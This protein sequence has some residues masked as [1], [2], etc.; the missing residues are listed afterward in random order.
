MAWFEL[1]SKGVVAAKFV[2]HWIGNLRRFFREGRRPSQPRARRPLGESKR[3]FDFRVRFEFGTVR[4]GSGAS[5]SKR[6][7]GR[8]S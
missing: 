3:V 2:W 4:R 6:T 8:H 5:K 1:V 7:S